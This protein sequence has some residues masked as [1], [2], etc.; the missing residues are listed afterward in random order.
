M[1]AKDPD[2]IVKIKEEARRRTLE[3]KES[4]A[5]LTASLSNQE[6]SDESEVTQSYRFGHSV[7]LR[8]WETLKLDKIF[9]KTVGKRDPILPECSWDARQV[10]QNMRKSG[11]P[12]YNQKEQRG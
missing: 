1:L 4:N 8:L 11:L 9:A 10:A 5:P 3:I 12:I 6:L 2:V 7:I